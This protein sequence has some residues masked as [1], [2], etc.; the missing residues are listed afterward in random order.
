[1]LTLRLATSSD[2]NLLFEWVNSP[3]SLRNKVK[4]VT[5]IEWSVHKE[6]FD[7]RLNSTSAKIWIVEAD[8]E[9][10]GQV[11]VE[12][13]NTR[14][15]V[16]IF[17]DPLFRGKNVGLTALRLLMEQCQVI[18]P[19]VPLVAVVRNENDASLNLFSRAN[20]RKT[21]DDGGISCF[22]YEYSPLHSK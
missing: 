10:L 19:E 8:Q 20:F 11:R 4:S 15:L 9:A 22:V 7:K 1:M 12:Y 14:L 17:I 6:W 16:D 5:P 3:S 13:D 18:Y 2:V 21:S